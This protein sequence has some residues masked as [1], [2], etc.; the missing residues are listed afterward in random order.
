MRAAIKCKTCRRLGVSV[1]GREKCAFKRKP[2]P[3]G[4]HGKAFRRGSSEFGIQLREKQK[5]KFLY[6][7]RE[8]QFKN[9]IKRA[10]AKK[11][12]RAP[13]AIINA[14]EMRLDNIVYRLGFSKTRAAARQMVNHGHIFVDGRRVNIPSYTARIG[15]TVSIRAASSGRK[16]FENLDLSL[17]RHQVPSWL[18]FNISDKSAKILAHPN[19]DPSGSFEKGINIRSIIEYYSR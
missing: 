11:G 6:G 2:Y 12:T 19:S 9:I 14:L 7:L 3:P 15:Q 17:K 13:D 4:V 8:K 16:M 18:S 10:L 1:C 5:V